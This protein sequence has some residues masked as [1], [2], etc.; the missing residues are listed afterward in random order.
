[1]TEKDL[2]KGCIREDRE[3]QKE[4]FRR[5]AGKMLTVC[6]RYARHEMEAED[7]LQDAFIQVFD[8]VHT[9]QFRGSFEGWVRRIVVNTALKTFQKSAYKKEQIGIENYPD[10]PVAPMVFSNLGEADLLNLVAG[11]PDG[12]RV[13]FN[14][15]A[16]E[17]YSH[18]EIA[19]LLGIGESTS[20]SQ[21]VK[22]RK[23]LQSRVL[24]LQKV[25][26]F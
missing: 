18:K 21:L 7:I 16:I 14:L 19:E 1:M 9:F 22:A 17:G 10:N 15:Y 4:V 2:V 11:L 3:C 13:V 23:M 12:Y 6:R 5:Y 25:A 26:S 24:E 8:K 20:R